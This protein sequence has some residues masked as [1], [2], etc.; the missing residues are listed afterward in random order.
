MLTFIQRTRDAGMKSSTAVR[1]GAGQPRAA[2]N[3]PSGRWY[4]SL[5]MLKRQQEEGT[6]MGI[7]Q[8]SCRNGKRVSSLELLTR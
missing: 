2:E 8:K 3:E 5:A 7:P 4:I 6:G 1:P